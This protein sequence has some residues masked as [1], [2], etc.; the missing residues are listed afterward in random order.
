M[1]A[2][3]I[4]TRRIVSLG[5]APVAV[6]LAGL[7][8]WQGSNAAFTAESHNNGNNWETGSVGLIDDDTGAA[9]FALSNLTPGDTGSRCIVVTATSSVAGVVKTSVQNLSPQGLEN[10]V[11]LTID[12]GAGG[13]FADC[14]GFTPT[15]TEPVQ[16]LSA[17]STAH[18]TF[19][20]G[21]LPWTKGSGVES[22]T[23]KF[24]WVFDTT[25]LTEA[26]VNAL[27]G[28][29]VGVNFEWELQNS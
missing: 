6:L 29:S 12:Q 14:T 25:G 11:K 1:S 18:G 27:Q 9:M 5:A 17:L 28:K 24:T 10:N 8:V 4:R 26:E 19:A 20:N 13:S 16:S 22:K 15:A 21:V 23:Y 2:P 3:S 7:M